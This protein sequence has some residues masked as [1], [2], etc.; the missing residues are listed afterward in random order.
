MTLLNG[1]MMAPRFVARQLACPSGLLGR[2]IGRA[3]NW[4]NAAI[5]SFAI[6][7]LAVAPPDRVLEIGFGGGATLPL[8]LERAAFLSGIDRSRDAV[9]WAKAR[10]ADA[11]TTSRAEFCEGSVEALPF[12]TAS[13]EKV[14]TVNTVY[15]WRSL[16]A[17]F[18]EIHRVLSPSG[19]VVVG[20]LPKE[21]MARRRMPSHIFTLRTVEDV[22]ASLDKAGFKEISVEHPK[23]NTSWKVIVARGPVGGSPR[24]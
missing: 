20:F 7:Q 5:N 14:Y 16:D 10:F 11:V 9:A 6:Q 4:H 15:F 3:M 2:A 21:Q 23:P 12:E 8:L 24:R 19:R 1:E 22:V 13:F 18:S 17:G